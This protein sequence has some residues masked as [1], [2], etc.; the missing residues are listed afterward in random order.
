MIT[1]NEVQA[2]LLSPTN[3]DYYACWEELLSTAEKLSERWSPS[4]TN[5]SDPGIVLLKVLTACCDKLNYNIDKNILEAFMPSASQEESMRKLCSLLGYSM[6]YYRSATGEATISFTGDQSVIPTEGIII[7]KFTNLKDVDNEI[8]YITLQQITLGK[9]ISI[10]TTDIMEGSLQSCSTDT[11]GVISANMLDSNYRYY[12]PETGIA[13][14]GIFITSVSD[15]TSWT[16]VDNLNT[17]I[18]GAKVF[19]FG[20]DSRLGIPYVQFPSDINTIIENGV[21]IDYIRTNGVNGNISARR[22]SAMEKP[23][24]WSTE[25]Y[26]ESYGS[27]DASTMF[28]ITNLSAIT[29]GSDIET[30]DQAYINYKK[31]IGTFD[32][33]VTCRDYINK[34]YT[35]TEDLQSST[36]LVSNVIVSDIK[37]DINRAINI[38]SFNEYG[39]YYIDEPITAKYNRTVTTTGGSEVTFEE[40]VDT[41]DHFELRV[42]PFS[43]YRGLNTKSDF[44]NS[45]KHSTAKKNEI[46]SELENYKTI[47]HKFRFLDEDDVYQGSLY[48]WQDEIVC[49]KNYLRLNAKITTTYKVNTVE[50][51]SILAIVRAA[52]YEKFNLRNI[53]FGEEIPYDSIL[54]CI[55]NADERIKNVSLDEPVLVTKF[56]TADNQEYWVGSENAGNLTKAKEIYNKLALRNVLAGRI[57]LFNYETNFSTNFDEI[58]YPDENILSEYPESSD[59]PIV[60]LETNFTVKQTETVEPTWKT[61]LKDNEVIQFKSP[62]F[63]SILTYP[64]YVNYYLKLNTA[65]H[66]I[67]SNVPATFV[68]L[69]EYFEAYSTSAIKTAF[70]NYINANKSLFTAIALTSPSETSFENFKS[71]YC[72]IFTRTGTSPNYTYTSVTTYTSGTDYYYFSPLSSWTGYTTFIKNQDLWNG[73]TGKVNGIY[74]RTNSSTSNIP[75]KYIDI[76]GSKYVILVTAGSSSGTLNNYYIPVLWADS[77]ATHTADGLGKTVEPWGLVNNEEYQLQEGEY[78]LINYT[79]SNTD[80]ETQE[81]TDLV[82]NKW[83]CAGTVIKTETETVIEDSATKISTGSTPTKSTDKLIFDGLVPAN[84]TFLPGKSASDY[85][86]PGR[87]EGM[88][89]LGANEKIIIREP[90]IINFDK[91]DNPAYFYFILKN[92]V[93]NNGYIYFPFKLDSVDTTNHIATFSYTLQADEYLFYTNKNKIDVAFYGNGTEIRQLVSYTGE[94]PPTDVKIPFK[95]SADESVSEEEINDNGLNI[96]PWQTVNFTQT[97]S[98]QAAEYQFISLVAN[99]T[100]TDITFSGQQVSQFDSSEW[101][102]IDTAKYLLNGD[103]AETTIKKLKMVDPIYTWKVRPKLELNAGPT[104]YQTLNEN[105]EL[106]IITENPVNSN[107]VTTR[108][109]LTPSEVGGEIIPLSFK[110]NYYAVNGSGELNT[111]IGLYDRNGQLCGTQDSPVTDFKIKTFE[112]KDVTRTTDE[113]LVELNTFGTGNWSKLLLEP[114]EDDK[115]LT[116]LNVTFYKGIQSDLTN[117]YGNFA[118]VL[119]YYL[120]ISDYEATKTASAYLTPVWDNTT[121]SLPNKLAILNNVPAGETAIKNNAVNF[122]WWSDRVVDNKYYLKPG[123]NVLYISDSCKLKVYPGSYA[124]VS[125]YD[126]SI[127]FSDIDIVSVT[128]NNQASQASN[129]LGINPAIGYYDLNINPAAGAN[130]IGNLLFE[131]IRNIDSEFKFYYTTPVDNSIAVD[132]NTSASPAETL[133]TEPVWYSYNNINNKFVVSEID[134]DYLTDGLTIART[135]K[136]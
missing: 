89:T 92:E 110:T 83:Y 7:P 106:I 59:T 104:S 13:E 14:N 43:T 27:L 109:I 96:I 127:I 111:K 63:K 61:V 71:N 11:D 23:A 52:L 45:F 75:G 77:D 32:T 34:I 123:I 112:Q 18:V 88:F 33:L 81:T 51:A 54:E 66:T 16:D 125:E 20:F 115:E 113:T 126:E 72:F 97:V 4:Q 86:N 100:L 79:Q 118:T 26:S 122:T 93:N 67:D 120:A 21:Y 40:T 46:I 103:E 98:L 82:I 68:S 22:L 99:D 28:S 42:Y 55:E 19:K 124:T 133:R 49:I 117:K 65:L 53:D 87:P 90:I 56:M 116:S 30:I 47:S 136:L 57:A 91:S 107:S 6:K 31:V 60:K 9:N 29:N 5:E 132:I 12:L 69:K 129:M 25:D 108:T 135:S 1:D 121:S 85:V 39:L 94:T 24:L 74:K 95:K 62:N 101:L 134:A 41:M 2:T 76:T 50:A 70:V 37:D 38:C 10:Q 35:L 102:A 78:L 15:G 80:S 8:N 119:I 114:T 17:Q 58:K 36:N 73:I 64:A 44:E 84:T 105:D 131:S 48:N 130:D 3:K 128:N